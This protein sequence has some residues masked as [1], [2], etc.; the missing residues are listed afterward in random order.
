MDDN[1]EDQRLPHHRDPPEY[2][3]PQQLAEIGV[4]Y[5]R[6]NPQN[7]ENDDE[8]KKI[9]ETRGYSYMVIKP[10][11]DYHLRILFLF[12]YNCS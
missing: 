12:Q 9:R 1:G 8:L 2:V 4:L 6:L 10:Y 5:W 7:Y 3:S 11:L